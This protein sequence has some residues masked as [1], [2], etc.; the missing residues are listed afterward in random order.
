MKALV[1][2]L[3][4]A[5]S[6]AGLPGYQPPTLNQIVARVDIARAIDCAGKPTP[7][8]KAKCLGVSLLSDALG[9]ALD[10]A[11]KAGAAAVQAAGGAGA[12][13]SD[14]ERDAIAADADRALDRLAVEIA[15]VQAVDQGFGE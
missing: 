10:E 7:A 2:A 6:C 15:N 14:D 12:E 8:D 4:L 1:L 9:L 5:P 11:A 3:A 13:M